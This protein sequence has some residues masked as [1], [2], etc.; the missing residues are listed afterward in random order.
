MGRAGKKGREWCT[1]G[2]RG[3]TQHPRDPSL[4]TWVGYHNHGT[5]AVYRVCAHLYCTMHGGVR[6]SGQ[7]LQ[8]LRHQL[9]C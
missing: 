8:E 2:R 5:P 3:C 7:G 1:Q 9:K 4:F 6:R